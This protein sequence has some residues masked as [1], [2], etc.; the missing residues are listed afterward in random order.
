MT[1]PPVSLCNDHWVTKRMVSIVTSLHYGDSVTDF[2]VTGDNKARRRG[3]VMARS[4]CRY[5]IFS[6]RRRILVV[7]R[8]LSRQQRRFEGIK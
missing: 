5:G 7:M 6:S 4:T 8:N 2:F 3:F 1:D